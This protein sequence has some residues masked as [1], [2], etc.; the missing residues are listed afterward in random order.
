MKRYTLNRSSQDLPQHFGDSLNESQRQ[1]VFYNN[2]PLLLIAGAGS[3][4][5]KTIVHRVARLIHDGIPPES[6][7]LLT[8]TR[9]AAHEM[10]TRA[11]QLLD[12]RCQRV[13]GGT[14]HSFAN[15]LLRRYSTAIGYPEHFTIMDQGDT[16]DLIQM[17]RKERGLARTDKR[18]PKKQTIA[19]I[20]SQSI[21]T[22]TPIDQLIATDYPH[23]IDFITD[24]IQ[25][26]HDYHQKK[27]HIKV[28]DYDDLLIKLHDLLETH[29]DIKNNLHRDYRYI[30]IDEYQ[31][32]NTIQAAI[33]GHLVNDDRNLMV[34]GDDC[35]SIYSFRG[36]NFRNIMDFPTTYPDAQIITLSENYRSTQPILD[37]TNTMI[38]HANEKFT[39]TLTASKSTNNTPPAQPVYIDVNTENTQSRFICQKVLEQHESGTPLRDIAVLM[40]SGWHANDLELELKSHHI[41]FVK[42]GGF[43]FVESAHIKDMIALLKLIYNPAD[44]L[45]WHRILVLLDGLGATGATQISATLSQLSHTSDAHHTHLPSDYTH[46]KYANDLR[47]LTHLIFSQ[48]SQPLPSPA[49]I[50]DGILLFYQPVFKRTYD[51]YNKRQADIDALATI[52]HRFP[53][54]EAFL[55]EL[56]LDPPTSTQAQSTAATDASKA[57]PD[58]DALCLS[59]IHSAKG[60]EWDTVFMMSCV[61]GYIPSFQSLG[62]RDQLEE[63]RRLLY[64]ALTR[65]KSHLFIIKPHLDLSKSQYF[66]YSGIYFS[67][68]SR[69]LSDY[70][71]IKPLYEQWVLDEAFT[72]ASDP[73]IENSK[74]RR[75]YYF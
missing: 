12:G 29:T 44:Q 59:T 34:V 35:Q 48:F 66:R 10:L 26:D 73:D 4:K 58:Q 57:E 18:F 24:I 32:T 39:K 71:D 13:S 25:L 45:S 50:I 36:A 31:D 60:L 55:T 27:H 37:L 19:K 33:I 5:T 56:S 52:A 20:I 49:I 74:S 11:T 3:G 72:P 23:Y 63:E 65:A 28:M 61:D 47:Q 68:L 64:V 2:G 14:F 21:N 8:F 9:K 62:D 41:P 7:L 46:K 43:K 1:A 54:L 15:I 16:Q 6:I 53:T 30:M 22:T 67:K 75:M 69:F 51:D 70:D 40:R 42:Y 17:L 38:S